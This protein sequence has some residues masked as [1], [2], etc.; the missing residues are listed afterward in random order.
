MSEGFFFI[1]KINV[2][3]I[4]VKTI[5]L[6]VQCNKINVWCCSK[7]LNDQIVNFVIKNYF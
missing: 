1:Q 7:R 6:I 2:E 5:H 4:N 3:G